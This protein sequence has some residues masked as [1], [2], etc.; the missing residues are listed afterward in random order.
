MH[1]FFYQQYSS[2]LNFSLPPNLNQ[3]YQIYCQD[4]VIDET[5]VIRG[6]VQYVTDSAVEILVLGAGSKGNFLR[7]AFK[8]MVLKLSSKKRSFLPFLFTIECNMPL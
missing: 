4:I 8:V 1:H 6:L 2:F 5:D 3:S 7:Y